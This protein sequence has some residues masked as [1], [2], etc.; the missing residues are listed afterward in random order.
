LPKINS[1]KDNG[2]EAMTML[3]SDFIQAAKGKLRQ[4]DF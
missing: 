2:K 4:V 3:L 1:Y